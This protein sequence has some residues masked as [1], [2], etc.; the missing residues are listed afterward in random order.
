MTARCAHE[1]SRWVCL[2]PPLAFAAVPDPVLRTE[3]P[4]APL[5][6]QHGKVADREPK[7]SGLETAVATL[8]DQQAIAGLSVRKRIDGHA[9]SIAR[10]PV[11]VQGGP[12][13]GCRIR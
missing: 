9:E 11:R 1:T 13:S 4:A 5:A 2:Q 8:V 6:V 10:K 7:S 12:Q 3:H